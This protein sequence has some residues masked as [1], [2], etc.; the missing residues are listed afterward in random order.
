[1]ATLFA[2]TAVALGALLLLV[3]GCRRRAPSPGCSPATAPCHGEGTL[4][5][6]GRDRS[7]RYHIPAARDGAPKPLLIALH[8]HGSDG[9]GM[10]RLTHLD[11]VAD[12]GGFVVAY[13]D[14]YDKQ[15]NDSRGTTSPAQAGVD[16]IAFISALIDHAGRSFSVDPRRVYVTGMSNGAMMTHRIGCELAAKV[17]GIAPVAG[18]LPERGAPTCAPAKPL[19]V[20]MFH[21]T[22][23]R[24]VPYD[25]GAVMTTTRGSVLSAPATLAK[26]AALDGCPAASTTT[27]EPDLDPT[28]GTR[29][30]RRQHTCPGG[31]A[32]VLYTIDGGGHTWPGGPQYLPAM[33][34]GRASRDV[35]ASRTIARFF[36]LLRAAP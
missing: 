1:M 21:G 32:V 5:A 12:E 8:G 25:G 13:P 2:R 23:D 30:T 33:M 7:F 24:L 15:W 29:V 31:N 3:P 17:A 18:P 10:A 19:P 4:V 14:G 9:R 26:W 11:D 27:T 22:E 6:A 35:D 16:D 36:G 28:D 20:V 34:V